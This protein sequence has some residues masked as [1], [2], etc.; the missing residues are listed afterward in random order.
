MTSDS[1]L[2]S[3]VG[4]ARIALVL[5]GILYAW[6]AYGNLANLRP[7]RDGSMF[8]NEPTGELEQLID[9][10]YFIAVFTGIAGVAN[11]VLAAIA[12]K[13]PTLAA[14]AAMA[15]F[16]VYTALRL[17]QTGGGYLSTWLWWVSA[18]VLG[19]GSRAA[20]KASQLRQAA[21]L[22]RARLVA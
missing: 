6:T 13:R 12:G 11:V 20:Y 2:A 18:V 5:T 19:M 15:I 10:A 22:A 14:H 4:G 7:W 1:K 9:L 8:V 21:Q 17:Y 16:A 3:Y